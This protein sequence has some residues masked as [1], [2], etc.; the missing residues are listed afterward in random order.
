MKQ[1]PEILGRTG[2]LPFYLY[3]GDG[4]LRVSDWATAARRLE[5]P[6]QSLVNLFLLQKPVR[7]RAIEQLLGEEV[8]SELKQTNILRNGAADLASNSFSLL[9]FRSNVYFAQLNDNPYAYFGED[10]IALGT[11]QTPVPDG[12]ILDLCSG[13]GIQSLIAAR[14]AKHVTGV[15]INPKAWSV[16]RLNQRMNQSGSK[17]EFVNMSLTD[18]AA[19][20]TR[21]FDRILFNP[22]L[23]PVPEDMSYPFV[24][25]GGSDGLSV[26]DD[27]LGLYK[28]ALKPNGRFEFIGMT[29]GKKNGSFQNDPLM[30]LAKKHR[31][32]GTVHVLSRHKIG[33]ENPVVNSCAISLAWSNK[34]PVA[35]ARKK[36]VRYFLD[37]E[38]ECFYLFFC[39]WGN[40]PRRRSPKTS[41]VDMSFYYFGDWFA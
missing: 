8:V 35:D 38:Y 31:M 34:I 41:I 19:T 28:R 9:S 7:R 3:F 23:V 5:D 12:E 29:V 30:A 24:G 18:F 40:A 22:P 13:P 32:D 4:N 27:I 20:N 2:Y 11:Y 25:H 21:Q 39:S 10:S 14:S 15:E 36:L 6:L 33:E 37:S 16:A 1:L 26:T 17:V